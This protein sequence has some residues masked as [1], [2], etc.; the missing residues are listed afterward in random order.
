M[1]STGSWNYWI[2]KMRYLLTTFIFLLAA[3]GFASAQDADSVRREIKIV[4]VDSL[5][6]QDTTNLS[7]RERRRLEREQRAQQEP[8]VYKDSARIA[9]ER[10]T[11]V[12]VRRSAILPGWGQI[13]NK[14]WWKVPIIYGGVVGL[15]ISYDVA[16][17]GYKEY[18]KEAQHRANNN[19]LPENEKFIN[20]NTEFIIQGKD[21]YRRNRDLT[22]L[23][24]GGL[25][26]LN[27]IDAYIDA[28]MFRYD[29]S[30]DLS[31]KFNPLVEQP[32][33]T[34]A[35]R[36]PLIGLKMSVTIH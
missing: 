30:D 33:G 27:L 22:F 21:F 13:T 9:L 19:N 12:A 34:F 28:K 16:Q 14:K 35:G 29:I 8:E 24:A 1:T 36:R 32:M 23:L 25:Y 11:T 20:Y 4:S 17:S 31:L 7:R 5:N 10:M 26:A 6:M 2:G 15:V 18:L 3:Y